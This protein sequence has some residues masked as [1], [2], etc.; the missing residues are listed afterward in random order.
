MGGTLDIHTHSQVFYTCL[1]V[2]TAFPSLRTFFCFFTKLWAVIVFTT[3]FFFFET[4]TIC[5]KKGSA[6]GSL[7]FRLYL[8]GHAWGVKPFAGY[9]AVRLSEE[10]S[11]SA[12]LKFPFFCIS[13]Y[14]NRGSAFI[15]LVS[16]WQT[17]KHGLGN[18][19]KYFFIKKTPESVLKV[20]SRECFFYFAVIR[21]EPWVSFCFFFFCSTNYRWSS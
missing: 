6:M 3:F 8:Q 7:C 16:S 20:V 21:V 10:L 12:S 19:L 2:C 11:L 17:F 18:L 5:D 1:I 9:S 4:L 14:F 13:N 15:L